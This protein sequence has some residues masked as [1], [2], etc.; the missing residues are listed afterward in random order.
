MIGLTL[1]YSSID[2][3]DLIRDFFCSDAKNFA[4]PY[5]HIYKRKNNY[6]I[7]CIEKGNAA[8]LLNKDSEIVALSMLYE[9]DNGIMENGSTI[10]VISGYHLSFIVILALV[11]K[12]PDKEIYAWLDSKNEISKKI[13][14]DYLQWKQVNDI[15]KC[16]V[17]NK[18]SWDSCVDIMPDSYDLE[19]R[20]WFVCDGYSKEIIK[21]IIDNKDVDT[22]SMKEFIDFSE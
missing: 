18:N 4:D 2:D 8:F 21:N 7:K 12:N 16:V 10:S 6:F 1:K 13:Y 20:N 22:S 9:Y 14:L 19:D 5:N 15:S 3:T 11:L 17:L